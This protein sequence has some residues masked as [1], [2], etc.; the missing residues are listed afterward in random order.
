MTQKVIII[1]VFSGIL[2]F[3]CNG[4][5]NEPPEEIIRTSGA[6]TSFGTGETRGAT[7]LVGD[8]ETVSEETETA[9]TERERRT[10]ILDSTGNPIY[11]D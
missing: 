3:S 6:G 10:L 2:L 1:S 9:T 7:G 5:H 4:V 8:T 11:L